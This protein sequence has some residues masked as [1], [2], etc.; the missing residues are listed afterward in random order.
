MNQPDSMTLQGTIERNRS[1]Q[2][3]VVD[4]F[5]RLAQGC[6]LLVMVL[7]PW[8]FG[9]VA[10]WAQCLMAIG[11]LIALGIWWFESAVDPHKS[12][13][14]PYVAF[15]LLG[16]LAIALVQLLPLPEA[17]SFLLGRQV[18]I[19][20]QFTGEP[21]ASARIS[22]FP[23]GTW[24][25]FQLLLI[26][27]SAL[28][29]ASRYFRST[30]EMVVLMVVVAANGLLLSILGIAQKA[31]ADDR[32]FWLFEYTHGPFA[33]FVNRNN[34]A[35]YLLMTLACCA[36]LLPI[37]M[38]VRITS[39]PPPPDQSR[40]A[41]LAAISSVLFIFPGGTER[42]QNNAVDCYGD[43]INGHN[44]LCLS[45][46]KRSAFGQSDCYL[47]DLW[48]CPSTAKHEYHYVSFGDAGFGS[49]RLGWVQ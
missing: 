12:Q 7:S 49:V 36:G 41:L 11:L 20:Q 42:S 29:L 24:Q 8:G 45:W 16:G 33:T 2:E 10:Y 17:A 3:S 31:S 47:F 15:L 32:I 13:H 26:A 35:G 23:Q 39:G 18:E 6:V 40:D 48:P 25:I 43:Y 5:A 30:K 37:V 46:R 34:G 27:L 4:L 44:C 19:Y 14:I 28:L 38:P 9:S 21:A 22:L 1:S